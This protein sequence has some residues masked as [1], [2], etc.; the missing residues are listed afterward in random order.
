MWVFNLLFTSIARFLF[1]KLL[2]S[3]TQKSLPKLCQ[4]SLIVCLAFHRR[5]IHLQ[6]LRNIVHLFQGGLPTLFLSLPRISFLLGEF[7]FFKCFG[8]I[9]L[10]MEVRCTW[11]RHLNALLDL[12][13]IPFFLD[14]RSL[15]HYMIF[16]NKI[17]CCSPN[18]FRSKSRDTICK[19]HS[20]H[21]GI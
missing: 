9:E 1:K 2:S 4:F 15:K 16:L 8:S 14:L 17:Q 10:R 21:L 12:N 6:Y 5:F 11:I 18:W 3:S 13:P 7:I 20:T 19:I